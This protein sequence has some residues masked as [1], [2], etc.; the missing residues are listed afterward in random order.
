MRACFLL[1]VLV[2]CGKS[3]NAEKPPPVR[4]DAAAPPADAAPAPGT[5][6][7]VH[8]QGT[9]YAADTAVVGDAMW[10]PGTPGLIVLATKGGV[11]CPPDKPKEYGP[12]DFVLALQLDAAP[13]LGTHTVRNEWR[14]RS[15]SGG[16]T[17][18]TV[19]L[20]GLEPLSGTVRAVAPDNSVSFVGD[21]VARRC[22]IARE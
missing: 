5:R 4:A 7:T 15:A 6:L 8:M 19:T 13:T 21:F 12:D 9:G 10:M 2:A 1:V 14:T 3:D 16:I 22:D 18:T 11:A 20:T 17:D